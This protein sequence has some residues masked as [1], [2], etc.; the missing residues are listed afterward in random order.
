MIAGTETTTTSPAMT[1]TT[2]AIPTPTFP[3]A[4]QNRSRPASLSRN[5]R[6]RFVRTVSIGPVTRTYSGR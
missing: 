5:C 3:Q 2:S 6:P 1:I 4:R